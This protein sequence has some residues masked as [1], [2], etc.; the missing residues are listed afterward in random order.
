M[1]RW[2]IYGANGYTG[3]LLLE[4]AVAAGHAPVLGGRR[5]SQ[6][7][8]LAERH[9]LE[10]RIFGLD[11]GA[12]LDHG[13]AGL[14]A[15]VHCAGPFSVT[16][17]PMLDGCLRH[18]VDYLDITGEIGV[19][20]AIHQRS[21]TVRRA[22]IRAVPGVGFDVV[23][24]DTAAALLAEALPTA[25]HLELGFVGLGGVSPGTARTAVEGLGQPGAARIGGRLK[26]VPAGWRTVEVALGGKTRT[27]VSIPWGDVA[28][29]WYST[30]I[31]NI[32]CYAALPG[33]AVRWM[34]LTGRLAP[35][36]GA[37]PV[38]RLLQ[39]VVDRQV[40]GPDADA[41][42]RGRSYVWGR[43]RDADGRRREVRLETPE[44]Y[45]FTAHAALAAVERLLDGG[46]PPGSHTPTTAFGTAFLRGLDGVVV[47]D[48][49]DPDA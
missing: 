17:G 19:F 14:D 12:D 8:P 37:K 2:M 1:A 11:D 22:G 44:G 16:A 41:R 3:R 18:G 6:I 15:V 31:P 30:G 39:A 36:L 42:A 48:V 26:A 46:P 45:T 34:P 21:P 4:R 47:G 7:V 43:V 24:T 35:L 28:T 38:Q 32:T 9:G 23:P 13:L 10:H 27:L 40:T 33:S 5:V 49:L 29:A 20:E 25:T